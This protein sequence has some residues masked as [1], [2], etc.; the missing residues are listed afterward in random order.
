MVKGH[1]LNPLNLFSGLLDTPGPATDGSFQLASRL[2]VPPAGTPPSGEC[3]VFWC[4]VGDLVRSPLATGD[5]PAPHAVLGDERD[6]KA[7]ETG[8]GPEVDCCGAWLLDQTVVSP[9]KGSRLIHHLLSTTRPAWR[10]KAVSPG[11]G[12]LIHIGLARLDPPAHGRADERGD[13]EC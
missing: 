7:P 3:R 12:R 4:G 10:H 1:P 13:H 2:L 5:G 8:P 9:Q 11:I 6:G